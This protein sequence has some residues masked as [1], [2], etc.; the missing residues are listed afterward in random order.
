V[1]CSGLRPMPLEFR[2][3][4]HLVH[5]DEFLE[6]DQLPER[7]VF[8]GGGYI[9]FEFAHVAIR[10][11]A[12]VRIVEQAD[13]P[14]LRF[15]SDLVE[16]LVE[17][18]RKIGIQIDVKTQVQRVEKQAD[19]SY[20]VHVS[21]DGKDRPIEADMVVH[22]AGR[23]PALD[24][25]DP[26]T[27]DVKLDRHGIEVNKYLQSVSNPHVYAAGDVAASGQP[28]LTPVANEEGRTVA[29]NLRDGN[30]HLPDYGAV[31]AAVFTV[32]ALASVGISEAE[33]IKRGINFEIKRGDMSSWNSIRKVGGIAADYKILLDSNSKQ[34]LG[35]H[36]L[37]PHAAESI[38][39][40]AL[41]MKFNLTQR[42]LKSVLIVFPT[43]SSDVRQML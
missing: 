36:L 4:E 34:I 30:Q 28:K 5:S 21:G 15:E 37:G 38:N 6:T 33:A 26:A 27:G 25:L 7:I 39:L 19:G 8:V 12:Q 14:L 35:A 23:T 24:E 1:I 32:P 22:G 31:P 17:H 16:R 3:A 10:A 18:S 11:G 9:S 13:R 20:R 42:D 40:F 2:G 41:A 29:M 43:F